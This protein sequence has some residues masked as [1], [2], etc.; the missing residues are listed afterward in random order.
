MD[1]LTFLQQAHAVRYPGGPA[2]N[3]PHLVGPCDA[4]K[5]ASENKGDCSR[6]DKST[7]LVKQMYKLIVTDQKLKGDFRLRFQ[8][9]GAYA[10]PYQSAA[11][12][13]EALWN[14]DAS[15]PALPYLEKV[16][17]ATRGMVGFAV[18]M[19][20]WA[21]PGCRWYY[22]A[23]SSETKDGYTVDF[24]SKHLNDNQDIRGAKKIAEVRSVPQ[25]QRQGI[26]AFGTIVTAR[27]GGIVKKEIP[28]FS[29]EILGRNNE[30][31][32]THAALCEYFKNNPGEFGGGAKAKFGLIDSVTFT[33]QNKYTMFEFENAKGGEAQCYIRFSVSCDAQGDK[34][35]VHHLAGT[36][37]TR[38]ATGTTLNT[39]GINA[40]DPTTTAKFP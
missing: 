1:L 28:A 9:A 33:T 24:A 21:W 6:G 8:G 35:A 15:E 34:W 11:T 3:S 4:L 7:E 31:G 39:K 25:N 20:R 23:T 12:L 27:S 26:E 16:R 40:G 32:E 13:A 14:C 5:W 2:A 29:K 10:N 37:L 19:S 18:N 38:A 30:F 36:S 22:T 17:L